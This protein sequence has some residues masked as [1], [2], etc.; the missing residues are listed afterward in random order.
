MRI[1]T[2]SILEGGIRAAIHT[3]LESQLPEQDIN[4]FNAELGAPPKQA[5]PSEAEGLLSLLIDRS[6]QQN[7]TKNSLT[8]SL[9]AFNSP[10]KEREMR[11]YGRYLSE[12]QLGIQL[13]VKAL[14]KT[15][16]LIEKISNLS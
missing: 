8:K 16:Q 12:S 2:D 5:K 11:N 3:P 4:F 1:Q 10:N 15:T 9:N 7:E 6:H 13:T 14:N